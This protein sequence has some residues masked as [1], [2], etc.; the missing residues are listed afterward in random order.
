MSADRLPNP[1]AFVA[2]S[3]VPYYAFSTEPDGQRVADAISEALRVAV[4]RTNGTDA[5]DC[6]GTP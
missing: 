6:G 4:A 2:E 3:A 1:D 5:D